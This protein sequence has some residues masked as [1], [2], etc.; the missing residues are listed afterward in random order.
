VKPGEKTIRF[1]NYELRI[2]VHCEAKHV[3]DCPERKIVNGE[4]ILPDG[5]WREDLIRDAHKPIK[6]NDI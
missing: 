5:C 4:S 2:C 1:I 3:S 6:G